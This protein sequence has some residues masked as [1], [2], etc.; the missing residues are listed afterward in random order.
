MKA[1]LVFLEL[2]HVVACLIVHCSP[3]YLCGTLSSSRLSPD[4]GTAGKTSVF[5]VCGDME[6]LW[7]VKEG[8]SRWRTWATSGPP[9]H[10]I[11][12]PPPSS[13]H[14]PLSHCQRLRE[15]AQVW[16]S[17]SCLSILSSASLSICSHAGRQRFISVHTA[18]PCG[19]ASTK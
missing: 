4:R 1:L 3:D 12:P 17:D 6:S 18:S 15:E 13:S 11:K 16:P 8:K 5:L 9:F 14:L 19:A 7:Q 2:S 10:S